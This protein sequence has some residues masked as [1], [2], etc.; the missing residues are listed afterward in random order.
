MS[1]RLPRD[2][3]ELQEQADDTLPQQLCQSRGVVDGKEVELRICASIAL[4]TY[5]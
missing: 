1:E 3:A 4:G 2:E 5:S